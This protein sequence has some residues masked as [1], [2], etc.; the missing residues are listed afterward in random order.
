MTKTYLISTSSKN[1]FVCQL[2]SILSGIDPYR[3][4]YEVK[5]Q[6]ISTTD[7]NISY[8]VYTALVIVEPNKLEVI[9]WDIE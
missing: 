4:S 1:D 3:F 2:N 5:Y 7:D 9:K 6:P 8:I